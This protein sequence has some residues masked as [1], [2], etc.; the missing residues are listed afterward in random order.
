MVRYRTT[1]RAQAI[2]CTVTLLFAAAA[3]AAVI[4]SVDR[5]T[6]ELNES[7]TLRVNV[8]TAIDTEPNVEA[9]NEDFYIGTRSQLS[10]TTIVNGQISRSRTWTYVLMA[11]RAGE[12]TIP[13]VTVGNEQSDPLT[14]TVKPVSSTAPGE[15][16]IFITAEADQEASYVQAQILYTLKVYRAVSTRQPRLS[17]PEFS[18]VDVL[19]EQAGDER[20]YEAILDGK[21]Y[22][23]VERVYA[24][25]PQASGE[26]SIAPV[27]FEARVLRDGRITGRKVFRSEPVTVEVR[28]IPA[29]PP[30]YPD[31]AWLPAR[32]VELSEEWSRDADEL[33]AGE[34]ITRHIT[35]TALGQLSTQIP[36]IEPADT[37]ELKVYPDKPDLSVSAVPEGIL[38]ERSEQYAMIGVATGPVGLP[39]VELPWWD[40]DTGEWQVASLPARTLTILPSA[41]A[42]PAQQPA[43][44]P[45]ADAPVETVVVENTLWRRISEGLA[46]LWVLTA[47][48]WWWSRR[49]RREVVHEAP[50]VPL[51]RQ[52]SRLLKTA[53]KA[54]RDGDAAGVRRALM[55]WARLEWPDDAPRSIGAIA[56]RVDAPLCDE[57]ERLSASAYGPGTG[58]DWDGAAL[59]RAL[60]SISVRRADGEE[61]SVDGL[62][63]LMPAGRGG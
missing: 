8:D 23:V 54:A 11:K 38:A 22:N 47:F 39:P 31:A 9:L 36:A 35:V 50:T 33:P 58:G 37:A 5:S 30:D 42:L 12:L 24:L 59:A 10:N 28:P 48:G 6:V 20:S 17:E 18:G 53:R 55:E 16:D 62:P 45:A 40:L 41:D 14:I 4:A 52:Q 34:P 61:R 25:F 21:A 32:N 2:L 27:R 46:V 15:A 29:P 49:P 3:D 56:A 1:I 63:P 51:H 13:P 43:P 57:L 26:L 7:F 19:T 60:R 44:A